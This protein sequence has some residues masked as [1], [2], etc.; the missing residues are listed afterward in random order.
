MVRNL[1]IIDE[2]KNGLEFVNYNPFE[3]AVVI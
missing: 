1:N 3:G 2:L